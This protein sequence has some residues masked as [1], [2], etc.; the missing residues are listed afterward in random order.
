MKPE[1]LLVPLWLVAMGSLAHAAPACELDRAQQLFAR[2]PRP[3]ADIAALLSS[4]TGSTD[5]RVFLLEGLMARDNHRLDEAAA[6]LEKAHGLAPREISPTLELALTR[7]W[8]DEPR[9]ARVLYE[10]ALA[11]D[12]KSRAALLGLAR[13]ARAQYHFAEA[14]RIYRQ[15]LLA[16]PRDVE[17]RNGLAWIALSEKQFDLAHDGFQQVLAQS[18]E[19]VEA[20][21]GLNG[22]DNSWR[23]QVDLTAGATHSDQGTAGSGGIDLLTSL[24]ATGTL[25]TG[26]FHNSSELPSAQLT[27]QTLLPSNDF[28][29]GY[30][31]RVPSNYNLSLSYDYRDHSGL[32]AEHWLQAA[33]GSYISHDFQWFAGIR[34]SFGAPQWNNQLAQA[35][36]IGTVAKNWEVVGTGYYSTFEIAGPGTAS[37][38]RDSDYAFALDI[39]RQGPGNSFFNIGAGYSPD[40]DNFDIH[41]RAVLP[42]GARN[43]LLLSVEHISVNNEVQATIGWRCYFQ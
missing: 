35:G 32:P 23:Y 2:Q 21:D 12:P 25:E 8:R 36:L 19:N 10:Q 30:F 40:I 6:L 20:K 31:W 22:I 41:A 15:L 34:E 37:H 11:A 4:C 42:V 26:I 39:N 33:A 27:E 3:D 14:D 7:E 38:S 5:Y 24:D 17:A 43:A 29:V 9:A 18:P 1:R 13:V 16:N 28:R